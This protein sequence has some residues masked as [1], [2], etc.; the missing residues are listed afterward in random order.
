[1]PSNVPG[2]GSVI[3]Q[4]ELGGCEGGYCSRELSDVSDFAY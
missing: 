4:S 1:M 3:S 2:W